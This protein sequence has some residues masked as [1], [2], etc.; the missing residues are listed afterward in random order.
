[1]NRR[2][3]DGDMPSAAPASAQCCADGHD[4]HHGFQL[5]ACLMYTCCSHGYSAGMSAHSM[6]HDQSCIITTSVQQFERSTNKIIVTAQ[7]SIPSALP[8]SDSRSGFACIQ[9][10]Y[11]LRMQ[12]YWCPGPFPNLPDKLLV[13]LDVKVLRLMVASWL[14]GITLRF[15]IPP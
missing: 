10:C 13:R 1:M 9:I 3:I 5:L 2:P 15:K 12:A 4:C 8:Q 6:T 14:H 7:S 11:T